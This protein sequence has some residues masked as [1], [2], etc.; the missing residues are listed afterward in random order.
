MSP[1]D[2]GERGEQHIPEDNPAELRVSFSSQLSE[3]L[4][5]AR[6]SGHKVIHVT[7]CA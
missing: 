3:M 7:R 6:N 5:I 1:V 2:P 4:N